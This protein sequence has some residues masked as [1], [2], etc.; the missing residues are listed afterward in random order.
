MAL[1]LARPPRVCFGLHATI[2]QIPTEPLL[3]FRDD[4]P[5]TTCTFREWLIHD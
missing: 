1:V 4:P 5:R 2:Y 3:Q